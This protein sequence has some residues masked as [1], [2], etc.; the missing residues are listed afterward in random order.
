MGEQRVLNPRIAC[1]LH[2]VW[3]YKQTMVETS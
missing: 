1:V 2:W 3:M